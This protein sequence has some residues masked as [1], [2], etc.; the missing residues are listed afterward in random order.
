M[1]AFSRC[2][3]VLFSLALLLCTPARA[4]PLTVGLASFPESLQAGLSTNVALNIGRQLMSGLV[5]RNNAGEIVPDLAERWELVNDTTWRFHLRHG[6]KFHDG[7]VFTSDDVKYTLDHALDPK[8]AYGLAGRISAINNVTIVDPY[9]VDIGTAKP[10]PTLVVALA[11]IVIEPKLYAEKVGPEAQ[12]RHPIGTGPFAFKSYIPG[13]RLELVASPDYWRGKPAIE[14]VIFR[15]IPEASTRIASL[16]SG[17]TQIVEEVPV[18]FID[19]VQSNPKLGI[20]AVSTSVGLIL[21]YDVTKPPFD[22]PKV[23][24]AMDLA[25]DKELIRKEILKGKGEV[26]QGQ[27]LTS[28]TFGFNPEVKARGFDPKRAKQLLA[29][30]GYPNGFTTSISTM[31]GRYLSDVDIANAVSG[32][33]NEVGIKVNI[34]VMESGIFLKNLG[35]PA[36]DLGSIYMIGWYSF[37][38]ADFAMT[39]FTQANKRTAWTN[40]EFDQLFTKARSTND[41]E[42]RKA[43]Y[44]R[45]AE[46]MHAENPSM[47]LF[48]LP[49]I[50]G[51][52]KRLTGFSAPPDRVLRLN[53]AVLH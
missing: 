3:A 42:A 51:V 21:T 8:S 20:A 40:P 24:E 11:D 37:G 15:L 39:W 23:R 46:I 48:G 29:E 6:V 28:N 25:V 30:A 32:M 33:L 12:R 13:D 10:F 36:R 5:A 19:Q 9:T 41:V 2:F 52:S 26:L 49:T 22:N 35:S 31:S 34:N 27:L 53:E 43:A 17:E 45:M 16:L 38:D 50:Y 4:E 18:D 1:R 14:D 7:V 44:A 47:F